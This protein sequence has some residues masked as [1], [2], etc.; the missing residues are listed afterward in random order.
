MPEYLWTLRFTAAD[1]QQA[2]RLVEAWSDTVKAEYGAELV[3]FVPVRVDDEKD[4][5]SD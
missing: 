1:T 5:S 2:R 4:S 3:S